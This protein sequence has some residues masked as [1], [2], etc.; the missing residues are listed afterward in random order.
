MMHLMVTATLE[1]SQVDA[2]LWPAVRTGGTGQEPEP[3]LLQSFVTTRLVRLLAPCSFSILQSAPLSAPMFNTARHLHTHIDTRT[4][5]DMH[6]PIDTHILYSIDTHILYCHPHSLL[7]PTLS[8]ITHIPI[9]THIL[10][11][12]PHKLLSPTYSFV[13]HVL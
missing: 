11:C 8:I 4:H 12:Y 1:E 7:S 9:V 13:T 3:S 2:G 6:I 10:Y 5:I